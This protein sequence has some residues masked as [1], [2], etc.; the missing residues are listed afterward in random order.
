M[1][2]PLFALLQSLANTKPLIGTLVAFL[3][4]I[5]VSF[6]LVTLNTRVF[7]ISERTFLP[8]LVYIL[9]TGI[10][11]ESQIL[12]PSIPAAIFLILAISRIMDG[13][14]VQGTAFSFF[15]AGML[16]SIGALFYASLI[17]FGIILIIGIAIM[18]TGS[19]REIIIALLGL[20]TPIF[21]LYGFFYVSGKDMTSLLSAVDYNLFSKD[22]HFAF[23][24]LRVTLLIIAG[25][26]ILV[27]LA[28]LLTGINAKKIKSRKT[29]ILLFWIFIVSAAVFQIFR[30]VSI[31]IIWLLAITPCY[32]ISHY[33]VFRRSKW[34]PEI[35]LVLLFAVSAAAQIF[36]LVK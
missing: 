36:S 22:T 12:N 14:K 1:P 19:V 16:I 6:L 34:M 24:G 33:F 27:C 35:I 2:M 30:P 11:P 23:S 21:V 10:V 29:F 28:H 26:I 9:L 31:E 17:W 20:A 7:F 4:V 13:Y 18:R 5:L 25:L 32:I 15:D 3:L 8:A